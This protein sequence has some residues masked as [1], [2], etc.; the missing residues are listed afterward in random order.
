VL[1]QK[2]GGLKQFVTPVKYPTEGWQMSTPEEQ[3]FDSAKLAD[4]LDAIRK[5]GTLIHS[6]LIERHGAMVVDGIFYPYNGSTYHDIASV[7]KSVMTTLIGIAADQGKLDL[8]QPVVSFFPERI[9][10]NRDA[11][12]EQLT[13]RHLVSMS[14]GLDCTAQDGEKTLEEMK[15]SSDWI[16]FVLDRK[17]IYD[18]GVLQPWHAPALGYLTA[19]HRHECIAVC[20]AESVW[21]LR[22]SRGR[23][24]GRSTGL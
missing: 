7:T 13:V 8:D 9:I 18:P 11:R 6:L 10:A 21:A 14:S 5:N 16:Q 20:Q 24:A 2:A 23:L 22:H 19:S 4:G 12:K 3:G 1:V 15:D 17:M